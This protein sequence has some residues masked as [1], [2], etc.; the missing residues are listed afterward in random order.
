MI[1]RPFA[2]G[3]L[4]AAICRCVSAAVPTVVVE[5]TE[6]YQIPARQ[7]VYHPQATGNS[8]RAVGLD[9]H[10]AAS[11][12]DEKGHGITD[13]SRYSGQ[14]LL[15]PVTSAQQSNAERHDSYTALIASPHTVAASTVTA[16]TSLHSVAAGTASSKRGKERSALP[17]G[18][19]K[20]TGKQT[21]FVGYSGL[22][23]LP[24]KTNAAPESLSLDAPVFKDPEISI[25]TAIA[26][27]IFSSPLALGIIVFCVPL[28]VL[29]FALYIKMGLG[30]SSPSKSPKKRRG[31][32]H[33]VMR[34]ISFN[35]IISTQSRLK[36]PQPFTRSLAAL[37][38]NVS[39]PA[40]VK[41]TVEPVFPPAPEYTSPGE[42]SSR[43]PDAPAPKKFSNTSRPSKKRGPPRYDLNV[44]EMAVAKHFGTDNSSPVRL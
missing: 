36:E 24:G 18:D 15:L 10:L 37:E 34:A 38:L 22:E 2:V 8:L 9:Y 33:Q 3:V 20:L 35:P 43:Q 6:Y 13:H 23:S 41:S 25:L 17:V 12:R 28:A 4:F 19:N 7:N 26:W 5:G 42:L 16:H 31:Y 30:H 29:P 11:L 44:A 32:K 40:P 27:K 21:A 1:T 39:N 14:F